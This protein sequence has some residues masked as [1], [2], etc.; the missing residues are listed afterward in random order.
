MG[1]VVFCFWARRFRDCR[2]FLR[3]IVTL[4]LDLVK[5]DTKRGV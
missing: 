4:Q 3:W 2:L 1:A 5:S